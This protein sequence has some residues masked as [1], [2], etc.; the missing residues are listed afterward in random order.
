MIRGKSKK[1]KL[2]EKAR[3]AIA[4]GYAGPSEIR[5]ATNGAQLESNGEVVPAAPSNGVRPD[6]ERSH[7]NPSRGMDIALHNFGDYS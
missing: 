3:E 2:A 7:S 1:I 6:P 4:A 5:L